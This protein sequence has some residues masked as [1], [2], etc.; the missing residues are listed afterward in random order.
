MLGE[1]LRSETH[2]CLIEALHSLAVG[3][4]SRRVGGLVRDRL[5]QADQLHLL[6]HTGQ[7]LESSTQVAVPVEVVATGH[8]HGKDRVIVEK[9]HGVEGSTQKEDTYHVGDMNPWHRVHGVLSREDY[10]GD[11]RQNG[12][13]AER[14]GQSNGYHLDQIGHDHLGVLLALHGGHLFDFLR[15]RLGQVRVHEDGLCPLDAPGKPQEPCP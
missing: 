8:H 7:L 13:W 3:L 14:S 15:D 6:S 12:D 2:I 11:S 9:Q 10:I 4:R 5:E 1:Y